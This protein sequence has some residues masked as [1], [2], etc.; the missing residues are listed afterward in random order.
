M[1]RILIVTAIGLLVGVGCTEQGDDSDDGVEQT[2][3]TL[4][5][6]APGEPLEVPEESADEERGAD[7]EGPRI[8]G[9]RLVD[10]DEEAVAD[11][12]TMDEAMIGDELRDK[13]D[14]VDLPV[15]LPAD[16]ELL[17]DASFFPGDDVYNATIHV[18]GA[19]GERDHTITING[20]K[21]EPDMQED[22]LEDGT[23]LARDR[24]GYDI[25][26][27]HK[28]A[29]LTF[30]EFDVAYS[31][32]VECNRPHENEHCTQDRYIESLADSMTLAK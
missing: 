19:D 24:E 26:R 27:I 1:Q 2:G 17:E 14:Q 28:I 7:E 29:T 5:A 25:T 11:A 15:M 12:E 30:S 23:K 20:S 9:P 3:E 10:F 18:D 31:I 8:A 16:S 21:F 4:E 32:D 6:E 22:L 13:I